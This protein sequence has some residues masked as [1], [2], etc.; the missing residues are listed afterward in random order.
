MTAGAYYNLIVKELTDDFGDD[1][2]CDRFKNM[3]LA[4]PAQAY[5]I[6]WEEY[7]DKANMYS[8]CFIIEA[9][10]AMF[11]PPRNTN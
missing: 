5:S 8:L 1:A 10:S 3:L 6:I 7:K 9:V 11:Q 4:M 2:N